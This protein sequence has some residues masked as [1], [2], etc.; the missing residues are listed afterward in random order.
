MVFVGFQKTFADVILRKCLDGRQSKHQ[1]WV[2]LVSEP[3][4]SA[5]QR[6]FA[7]DRG[8]LSARGLERKKLL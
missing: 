2:V 8:V 5:K 6:E 4:C 7:I 1:L 3:E